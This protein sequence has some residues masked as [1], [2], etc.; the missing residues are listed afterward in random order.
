MVTLE[1]RPLIKVR[2]IDQLA[3]ALTAPRDL[4]D[5]GSYGLIIQRAIEERLQGLV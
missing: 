3:L 4:P 2:A 1:R 5:A